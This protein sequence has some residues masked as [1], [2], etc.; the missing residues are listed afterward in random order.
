M[1]GEPIKEAVLLKNY[2]DGDYKSRGVIHGSVNPGT[3][4]VIAKVPSSTRDE[5]N[6]DVKKTKGA[7]PE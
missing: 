5:V 6:A 7:F 1:L 3:Q 2:I 4:K